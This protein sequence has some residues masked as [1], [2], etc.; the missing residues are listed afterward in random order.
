MFVIITLTSF[1]GTKLVLLMAMDHKMVLTFVYDTIG[2]HVN[3]RTYYTVS[4]H[5]IF[6]MILHLIDE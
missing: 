1:A 3:L 2:G 5:A 6:D 4:L